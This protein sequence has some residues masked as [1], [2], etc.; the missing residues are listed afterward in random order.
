[1][2][3]KE[4]V[5]PS[6]MAR[7]NSLAKQSLLL[8]GNESPLTIMFG[9]DI[10]CLIYKDGRNLFDKSKFGKLPDA[11][12]N[13]I[14][15]K[16]LDGARMRLEKAGIIKAS[17]RL[18]DDLQIYLD[19]ESVEITFQPK[20]Y[21]DICDAYT[22][23][24]EIMQDEA[25]KFGGECFFGNGHWHF[26]VTQN[27]RDLFRVDTNGPNSAE[28]N[29]SDLFKLTCAHHLM[30]QEHYPAFFIPPHIAD[31][32]EMI[33]GNSPAYPVQFNGAN[34]L[35]YNR[36]DGMA[37]IRGGNFN[38]PVR[39]IEPRLCH[40]AP[41]HPIYF[42]LLSI[43]NALE[44]LDTNLIGVG[45]N[46]YNK[47]DDDWAQ[48][49]DFEKHSSAFDMTVCEGENGYHFLLEI[50]QQTIDEGCDLISPNIAQ[51]IMDNV[52]EQYKLSQNFKN[53][54]LAEHFPKSFTPCS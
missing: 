17:E 34:F 3:L 29:Y 25:R 1:M 24:M 33:E 18:F 22:R 39:T 45:Q 31:L 11:N 48:G 21:P 54:R 27:D 23:A 4:K 49:G 20:L 19:G 43:S 35:T 47:S 41:T 7:I 13:Q 12:I 15:E 30:L 42:A 6:L 52:K 32:P 51:S 40:N 46:W 38:K 5:I 8:E 10:E 44:Y 26:S 36:T 37:S 50:T 28:G 9:P 16:M 53:K 2:D 14:H